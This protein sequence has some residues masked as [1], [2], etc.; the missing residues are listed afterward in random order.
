[1][2]TKTISLRDLRA[3][4]KVLDKLV[5]NAWFNTGVP[6]Q[7]DFTEVR[8]HAAAITAL[9]ADDSASPHAAT[10]TKSPAAAADNDKADALKGA[11]YKRSAAD[12]IPVDLSAVLGLGHIRRS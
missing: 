5:T 2:P 11:D 9:V 8:E 6:A 10:A 1:M 4:V 12:K 7:I 3:R